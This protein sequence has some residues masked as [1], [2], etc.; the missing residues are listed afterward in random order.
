MQDCIFCKIVKKEIPAE[1]VHETSNFVVFKDNHPKAPVHLL[2]V[3][4]EHILDMRSASSDIWVEV[5]KIALE[6]EKKNSLNGFVLGTNTGE[7]AVVKHMHVHFL[8]KAPRREL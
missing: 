4:K 8:D 7:R 1:I 6:L 2:I 3:P 5:Q